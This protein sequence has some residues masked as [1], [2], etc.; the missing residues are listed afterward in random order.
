LSSQTFT[1]SILKKKECNEATP[2]NAPLSWVQMKIQKN[3]VMDFFWIFIRTFFS[4]YIY[5]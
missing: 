2:T 3:A 4:M 5:L 1:Q